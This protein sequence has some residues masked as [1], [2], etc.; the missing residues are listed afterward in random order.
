MHS[1]AVYAREK[2]VQLDKGSCNQSCTRSYHPASEIDPITASVD[3]VMRDR[4]QDPIHDE[5][6]EQNRTEVIIEVE[7]PA[8]L[9]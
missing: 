5:I 6:G 8:K 1:L 7:V 4:R 2:H 9:W 3:D